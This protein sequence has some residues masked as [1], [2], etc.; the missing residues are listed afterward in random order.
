MAAPHAQ[1][2]TSVRRGGLIVPVPEAESILQA[3]R[4]RLG[5][6]I[7]AGVPAHVTVL[8]P[9]LALTDLDAAGLADLQAHFLSKPAVDVTFTSV[10]LFPDVVYLAPEPCDWF[11]GC[12]EALSSRFGLL[13]YGGLHTKVVPHL[14]V[15]RHTDQAVLADI[16]QQ[17]ESSLPLTTHVREVWLMEELASGGW[18]HTATFPLGPGA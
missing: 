17:L 10:G 5:P 4:A 16:A 1:P 15:A 3:W 14:T 13:P 7:E 11:I 12:T 6:T 2:G 9:F 8:F 18:S